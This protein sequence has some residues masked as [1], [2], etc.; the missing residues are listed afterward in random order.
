MGDL[1]RFNS[2][3]D[4]AFFNNFFRPVAS[5]KGERVPAID[6]HESDGGYCIKVDLPGISK[7]DIHVTLENGV[8]T[9]SAETK[10]EDKE[11]KDGK[12]IRQERHYGQYVRR[13]SVGDNLDPASIKARFENGVLQLDLPKP[14][15][16]APEVSKVTID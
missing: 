6:V 9:I 10:Q 1:T 4:D 3:F 15:P 16:K 2:L 12:I 8:L 5:D 14:E 11:E 13:L 7:D